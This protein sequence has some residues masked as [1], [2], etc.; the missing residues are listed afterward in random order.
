M[1]DGAP[2]DRVFQTA[3]SVTE[4]GVVLD[5]ELG[6]QRQ[7]I[8]FFRHNERISANSEK[9]LRQHFFRHNRFI[10]GQIDMAHVYPVHMYHVAI[11][12]VVRRGAPDSRISRRNFDSMLQ[13]SPGHW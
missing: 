6:V 7:N 12:S 11:P 8:L 1:R 10:Q 9:T 3:S 4:Q 2:C 13:E 5:S